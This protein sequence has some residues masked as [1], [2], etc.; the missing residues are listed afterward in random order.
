MTNEQ[1][2]IRRECY[3]IQKNKVTSIVRQKRSDFIKTAI[4][5]AMNDPKRVEISDTNR[6]KRMGPSIEL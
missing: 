2:A 4:E 5:E 6:V 1:R 3:R